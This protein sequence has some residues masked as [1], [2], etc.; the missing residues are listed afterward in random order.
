MKVKFKWMALLATVTLA[1]CEKQEQ[2]PSGTDPV[3]PPAS[4]ELTAP[5][6]QASVGTITLSEATATQ[7]V[8]NLNWTAATTDASVSVNYVI[9]ANL[10]S[11][12]LF[13]NPQQFT[14]AGLS[15]NFTGETLNNMMGALGA[16]TTTGIKFAVYASASGLESRI[17]NEVTIIITPYQKAVV[18][19]S[20]LYVIGT[21]TPYLWDLNAALAIPGVNG[22]YSAQD[23]PLRVEPVANNQSIKFAFS[24]DGSDPRFAGQ[25]VGG[26]FGDVTIVETGEGYEFFPARH[27]YTNGL[28]D[29]SVNLNTLKF[30]M[31]RKGDLPPEDLPST[32]YMLGGCFEWA[33][34]FT[35]TPLSKDSENIYKAN[36]VNMRFGTNE[37]PNG[38]KIFLAVDRWAPYYAMTD[39][40]SMGN[41]KIRLVEDGDVPQFYPGK[42]GYT[43]GVYNITMNFSTMKADFVRTGDIPA[44]EPSVLY[45][46]GGCFNPTW[47]FS[48]DLVLNKTSSGVYEGDV[49]I[50]QAESWDGFKIWTDKNWTLSYGASADSTHDNIIIVD[51]EKY[52]QETGAADA[53]IYPVTLGYNPGTYHLVLNLN[54]MR[55]TMT[56]K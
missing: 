43:D 1:G 7:N 27:S 21:A 39:D 28:Y 13:T 18:F 15:H 53:Q 19:P 45:L 3:N 8:L 42:L 4:K 10:S 2:A 20:N 49:T 34:T 14:A 35:G 52:K 55:L 16:T 9:Y 37:N 11:R 31:T 24:R 38:F 22:V 48:D 50:I 51:V 23:L 6:L 12:D 30:T 47:D 36:G 29:I 56:S 40:S 17:S 44:S 25:K 26:N 46:N 33:W 41:V 5:T 54:T 32:L